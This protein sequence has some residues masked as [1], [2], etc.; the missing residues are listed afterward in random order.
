VEGEE[1][2]RERRQ[3]EIDKILRGREPR[4]GTGGGGGS[5]WE[6]GQSYTRFS[7]RKNGC[8]GACRQSLLIGNKLY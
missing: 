7:D 1:I 3:G 8:I 4:V 6:T 2:N 5:R